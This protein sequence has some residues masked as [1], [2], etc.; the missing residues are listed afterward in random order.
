MLRRAASWAKQPQPR[1][2]DEAGRRVY[3]NLRFCEATGFG[4]LAVFAL[5][6]VAPGVAVGRLV[7]ELAGVGW[8]TVGAVLYVVF[9][10]RCFFPN[11]L[12]FDRD[13]IRIDGRWREPLALGFEK[14]HEARWRAAGTLARRVL[15]PLVFAEPVWFLQS[16]RNRELFL[17]HGGEPLVLREDEFGDLSEL[18]ETLRKHRVAGMTGG[19]DRPAWARKDGA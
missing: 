8:M 6:Y 7:H 5:V 17:M 9:A 13:G 1:E 18:V 4:G 15:G 11:T 19:T 10:W 12:S 14:I 3:R 2:A 16:A